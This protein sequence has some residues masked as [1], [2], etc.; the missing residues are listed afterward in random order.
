MW[1]NG[2]VVSA[3][4]IQTRGPGF[5]SWLTYLLT[6][7]VVLFQRASA[8]VTETASET[9]DS[10]DTSSVVSVDMFPH[11]ASGPALCSS[12]HTSSCYRERPHTISAAYDRTSSRPQ[13]TERTFEPPSSYGFA[14][15]RSSSVYATP[16]NIYRQTADI[17]ARPTL[18]GR[19]FSQG[20]VA[21]APP[22]VPSEYAASCQQ[23]L[24][25][26]V[27]AGSVSNRPATDDKAEKV[28]ENQIHRSSSLPSP[29]YCDVSKKK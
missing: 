13:V 28:T 17:Y 8:G 26:N 19:R 9:S 20:A 22:I 18:C 10:V 4:G 1:L 29:V 2:I 12:S 7:L 6:Y 21:V 5:D 23:K 15:A 14:K 3:L 11:S 16:T 25:M 27:P 24:G